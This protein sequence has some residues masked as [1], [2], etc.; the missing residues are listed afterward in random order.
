M[1][2]EH[3]FP[4]RPVQVIVSIKKVKAVVTLHPM[5]CWSTAPHAVVLT[6]MSEHYN[7]V[8][9]YSVYAVSVDVGLATPLIP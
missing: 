5:G 8:Y 6:L 7:C 9:L 3:H 2:T 1:S 4:L